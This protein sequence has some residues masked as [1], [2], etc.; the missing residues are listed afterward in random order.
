M[1]IIRGVESLLHL[2]SYNMPRRSA[3]STRADGDSRDSRDDDLPTRI[4]KHLSATTPS[5]EK[6][7]SKC[8]D[9]LQSEPTVHDRDTL[10]RYVD[11]DAVPQREPVT[12]ILPLEELHERLDRIGTIEGYARRMM[13]PTW[14]PNVYHFAALLLAP[15]GYLRR[16]ADARMLVNTLDLHNMHVP[17]LVRLCMLTNVLEFSLL[18]SNGH[19]CHIQGLRGEIELVDLGREFADKREQG[20]A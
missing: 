15:I 13:P 3:R 18:F 19:S 4:A 14:E 16:L 2:D 10:M 8:L 12:S 9:F 20:K 1:W 17:Q 6:Q 11:A 7:L 5:D